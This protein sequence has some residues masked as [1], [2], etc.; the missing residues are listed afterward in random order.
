ML[1]HRFGI[2]RA[3]RSCFQ[4]RFKRERERGLMSACSS[5]IAF[6]AYLGAHL[7]A[8]LGADLGAHMGADLGNSGI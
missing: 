2:K 1:N 3:I 6:N 5:C 4:Y 8:D 7:G